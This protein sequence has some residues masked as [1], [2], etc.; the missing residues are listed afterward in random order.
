MELMN[1]GHMDLAKIKGQMQVKEAKPV[2]VMYSIILTILHFG[3]MHVTYKTF[4]AS[5]K[6]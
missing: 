6:M 1:L 5:P 2:K 3:K 4:P